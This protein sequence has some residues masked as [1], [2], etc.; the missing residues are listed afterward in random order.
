MR[1]LKPPDYK[2]DPA[3]IFRDPDSVGFALYDA[4]HTNFSNWSDPNWTTGLD[5]HFIKIITYMFMAKDPDQK[6]SNVGSCKI[7]RKKM[8]KKNIY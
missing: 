3:I 1:L 5:N 4:Y 7:V 6:F 2:T 8:K